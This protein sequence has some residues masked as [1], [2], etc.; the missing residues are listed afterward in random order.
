MDLAGGLGNNVGHAQ[1]R[2]KHRS[3]NTDIHLLA[4]ADCDGAAV[5]HPGFFQRY[6][7]QF[8]DD[9]GVI[10]VAAHGLDLGFVLVHGDDLFAR[11]GQR[12]DQRRTKPTQANDA[13]TFGRILLF[14]KHSG[15]TFLNVLRQASTAAWGHAALRHTVFRICRAGCPHPAAPFTQS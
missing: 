4:N 1:L 9:K 8:I 14:V 7:V 15:N 5:L 12:F 13:V 11:G 2:D 10:G 6:F 3:Q